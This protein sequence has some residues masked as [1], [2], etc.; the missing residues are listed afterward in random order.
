MVDLKRPRSPVKN[1]VP[2][3]PNKS[4]LAAGVN[5]DRFEFCSRYLESEK[6]VGHLGFDIA[7]LGGMTSA[8]VGVNRRKSELTWT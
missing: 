6:S 1:V 8:L 5:L 7:G 4:A 2:S 3:V